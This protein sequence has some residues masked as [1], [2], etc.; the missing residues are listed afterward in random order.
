M[1]LARFLGFVSLAFKEFKTA[2]SGVTVLGVI[3]INCT[4]R[5]DLIDPVE[6]TSVL[7][8]GF[9]CWDRNFVCRGG[10][11]ELNIIGYLSI[12]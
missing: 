3:T 6:V 7:T 1:E 2:I 8:T 10:W 4:V 12:E 11:L 5:G 9:F